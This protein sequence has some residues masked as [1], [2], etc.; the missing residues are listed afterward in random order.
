MINFLVLKAP[1]YWMGWTSVVP[2]LE[3]IAYTGYGFVPTSVAVATQL[4]AGV[5][6]GCVFEA[7]QVFTGGWAYWVA[8]LYCTFCLVVVLTKT[9]N[10]MV[11]QERQSHGMRVLGCILRHHQ[12]FWHSWDA[13]Q[14]LVAGAGVV[15]VF[16]CILPVS[17]VI[18]CQARVARCNACLTTSWYRYSQRQ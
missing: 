12:H 11:M 9:I 5:S 16:V 15:S 4:V 18:L 2:T 14:V 13:W 1:L 3:A 10:S 6:T 17:V 7:S 8:Y